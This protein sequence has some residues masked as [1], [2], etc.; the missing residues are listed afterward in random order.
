MNENQNITFI[1]DLGMRFPK[2]T[3]V[4][5]R[6]YSLC[7]C[8]KCGNE[9]EIMTMNVKDTFSCG[10]DN[11]FKI[12]HGF[13]SHRLYSIW[14]DMHRRCYNPKSSDYTRYGA[15]GVTVAKEWHDVKTFIEDMYPTFKEGLT[16]DKDK[17]CKEKG[18]YPP[19]YSKD[20]CCWATKTEQSRTTRKLKSNNTSGYR[21]VIFDKKYSKYYARIMVDNKSISLGYHSTALEAAKVRDKY[22][23]DNNLEHTLNDVL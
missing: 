4:K 13:S 20:T 21:G 16:L 1:K 8:N 14:N 12:T 10:C 5:K 9:F 19:I 15:I 17:L 22:I 3:S 7:L 11:G 18:I 23:I 2:A 6:R